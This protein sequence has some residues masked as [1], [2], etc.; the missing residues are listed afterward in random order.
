MF[1]ETPIPYFDF[2]KGPFEKSF[3]DEKMISVS[4]YFGGRILVEPVYFNSG[5][6]GTSE[7]CFIREGAAQR[8]EKALS[9]LPEGMTFKVFD[10]WRSVTAQQ[11]LYDKYYRSV[12]ENNPSFSE[13][14]LKNETKKFVSLPSLD[15]EN[16]S[17][18]NTGGAID[19]TIY[20]LTE[21]K[22]LNMGTGFDDFTIKANTRS[23]EETEAEKNKN[24]IEVRNNRRLLYYT[25]INAG[26]TN[27]PTEWWHYDYGDFFWSRYTKKPSIYKGLINNAPTGEE[28]K[29]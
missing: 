24:H 18:H 26:F 4:E 5:Y 9:F 2:P 23:F 16:P 15:P 19:L 17:V 20:S 22:E 27:L 13:E 7:K 12:K 10:G 11:S 14:Q 3:S 6:E 28:K 25:M 8:L 21:Q 29:Q 1:S